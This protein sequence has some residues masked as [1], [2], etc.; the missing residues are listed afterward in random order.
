MCRCSLDLRTVTAG[1]T[2]S[3]PTTRPSVLSEAAVEGDIEAVEELINAL[4]QSEVS[5]IELGAALN[6]AT[7]CGHLEVVAMLM[8]CSPDESDIQNAIVVAQSNGNTDM[9]EVLQAGL[10]PS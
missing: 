3:S 5:R 9:E 8:T 1:E 2:R 7:Q 4:D 10:S 6:L